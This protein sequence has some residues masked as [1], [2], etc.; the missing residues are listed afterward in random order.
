[1]DTKEVKAASR[2][3]DRSRRRYTLEEKL[4]IVEET[5]RPGASVSRI[6]RDHGINANLVFT[7]RRQ[8]ARGELIAPADG[9]RPTALLPICMDPHDETT[10]AARP[11]EDGKL[12]AGVIEIEVPGAFIRI[13]GRVE[14][15]TLT[16]V[17]GLLHRR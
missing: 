11:P 15:D 4:G 16:Q 2:R 9:V 8:S 13:L 5:H 12:Q 17:L 14:R 1:M 7:W 6:A 10:S 3:S